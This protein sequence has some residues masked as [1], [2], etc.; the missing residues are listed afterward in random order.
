MAL[1][2]DQSTLFGFVKFSSYTGQSTNSFG[3]ADI[4]VSLSGSLSIPTALE[5]PMNTTA[6]ITPGY[7]TYYKLQGW[8]PITQR[9]ENWHSMNEPLMD[10]PSG[11]ALDGV[12]VVGTWVDR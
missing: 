11:N 1:I 12:S 2:L 7:N 4:Q 8:N 3:T 5:G 6:Q 10:P 9:Y